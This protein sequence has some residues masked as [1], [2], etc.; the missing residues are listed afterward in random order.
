VM[1]LYFPDTSHTNVGTERNGYLPEK[2]IFVRMTRY[3]PS[4]PKLAYS[5]PGFMRV[6]G[7]LSSRVSVAVEAEI[8]Q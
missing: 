6:R 8:A 3:A 5:L 4:S 1:Y 2:L 7:I